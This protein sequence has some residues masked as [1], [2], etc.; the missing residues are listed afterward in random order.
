M[1]KLLTLIALSTAFSASAFA[2]NTVAVEKAPGAMNSTQVAHA[3]KNVEAEH[4]KL[5]HDK[6]VVKED[7]QHTTK[8]VKKLVGDKVEGQP[9]AVV[10][11]DKATVKA[12][13]EATKEAK[14]VVK[15]DQKD[16][17][18]AKKDLKEE[19]KA[20]VQTK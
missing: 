14:E 12:N 11:H 17:T 9:A 7:K 10:E 20:A 8:S 18:H 6:K 15:Q 3:E 1:K 19:K 4:A 2:Q 5:K 16:L 13:H